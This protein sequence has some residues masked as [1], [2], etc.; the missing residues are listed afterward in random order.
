MFCGNCGTQNA[1]NS[2]F[3]KNCG[4]QLNGAAQPQQS[5][6]PQQPVYQQPYYA[7]PKKPL[8]KK[9]IGIIAGG[10][11]AVVLVVVLLIVLLGGGGVAGS[12]E[13]V[14]ENY[15]DS[16]ANFDTDDLLALIPE[17]ALDYVAEEEGYDDIDEMRE[18]MKAGEDEMDEM[19]D[20]VD[21]FNVD[22][23]V[24]KTTNYKKA[25]LQDVQEYYE[26]EFNVEVTAA[27]LVK[28]E[29]TVEV[30]AMGQSMENS[31]EMEIPVIQ[32]DGNWYLDITDFSISEFNPF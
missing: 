4:A 13:E 12:P 6:Q 7:A 27:A 22:C 2:A 16:M 8:N 9:L 30:S 19:L 29:I 5:Q 15:I 21:S 24:L 14:A 11:A 1:D 3:C 18:E 10:A 20:M 23:E 26:E 28:V 32:I 31:N 17:A 25:D